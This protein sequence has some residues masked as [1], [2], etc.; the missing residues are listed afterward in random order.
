MSGHNAPSPAPRS[1]SIGPNGPLPT[2]TTAPLVNGVVGGNAPQS[3]AGSGGAGGGGGPQMTQQNLNQIVG[4]SFL[5]HSITT[6]CWASLQDSFRH[7]WISGK[8]L[9]VKVLPA[10]LE[11]MSREGDT[12][13]FAMRTASTG[14]MSLRQSFICTLIYPHLNI[15]SGATSAVPRQPGPR[16]RPV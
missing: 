16:G 4:D 11:C 6:Q 7:C 3:A 15:S 5:F 14:S 13:L 10:P 1:A 9:H 2:P 8:V 12:C